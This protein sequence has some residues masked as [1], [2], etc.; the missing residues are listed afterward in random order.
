MSSRSHNLTNSGASIVVVAYGTS[1]V[2]PHARTD[3][4][5]TSRSLNASRAAVSMMCFLDS[6][7]LVG[8]KTEG[9]RSNNPPRSDLFNGG[10]IVLV[11]LMA[12]AAPSISSRSRPKSST[13]C[14]PWPAIPG[15]KRRMTAIVSQASVDLPHLVHVSAT[16]VLSKEWRGVKS[17]FARGCV[18]R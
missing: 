14:T 11:L 4:R 16:P 12:N 9:T 18:V 2:Y 13:A 15:P 1:D 6:C 3:M 8:E 7:E 10:S 17:V 5:L